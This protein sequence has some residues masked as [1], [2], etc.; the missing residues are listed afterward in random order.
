MEE[1][2]LKNIK[3]LVAGLILVIC[4]I[5]SVYVLEHK[6][7]EKSSVPSADPETGIKMW[8]DAVNQRNIDRVYDLSP[9]QI[10]QQL[11]LP[12]MKENNLNNTLLQP[13]FRFTDYKVVDKQ[14]NGTNAKIAATLILQFPPSQESTEGKLVPVRYNFALFYQHGEWKIWTV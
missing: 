10:K 7:M 12:Q 11:T 3:W 4:L 5:G 8:I 14:Q 9:D 1:K 2:T 13:G 6:N